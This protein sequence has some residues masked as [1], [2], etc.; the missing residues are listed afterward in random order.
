MARQL[1]QCTALPGSAGTSQ[2]HRVQLLPEA[3]QSPTSQVSQL[4][5][6]ESWKLQRKGFHSFSSSVCCVKVSPS[7]QPESPNVSLQDCIMLLDDLS[8]SGRVLFHHMDGTQQPAVGITHL[9]SF[10]GLGQKGRC[11]KNPL[12]HST[13]TDCYNSLKEGR[14]IHAGWGA[15]AAV[16]VLSN[17]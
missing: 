9:F 10:I 15:D 11:C 5:L 1:C 3:G 17:V 6:A 13:V 4:C 8:L 2:A 12:L 7:V 16:T 14:G